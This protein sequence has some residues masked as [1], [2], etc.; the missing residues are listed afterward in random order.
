MHTVV[1]PRGHAKWSGGGEACSCFAHHIVHEIPYI[2]DLS[3]PSGQRNVPPGA[4]GDGQSIILFVPTLLHKG[5]YI[6]LTATLVSPGQATFECRDGLR[7]SNPLFESP[8]CHTVQF[9]PG[10]HGNVSPISSNNHYCPAMMQY[11]RVP[12]VRTS[13][14]P[15]YAPECFLRSCN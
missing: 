1:V 7:L 13:V 14:I 15:L 3:S 9:L 10:T 6:L 2:I 5:F 8:P 12:G 4:I 11:M